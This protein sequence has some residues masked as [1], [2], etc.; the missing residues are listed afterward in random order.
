VEEGRD[1]GYISLY[2]LDPFGINLGLIEFEANRTGRFDAYANLGRAR[3]DKY[4]AV[5][6]P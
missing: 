1:S 6:R 4:G 3:L 2:A 5:W